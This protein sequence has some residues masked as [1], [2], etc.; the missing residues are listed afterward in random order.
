M[1]IRNYL[2]LQKEFN[3]FRTKILSQNKLNGNKN[4]DADSIFKDMNN[5]DKDN[6]HIFSQKKFIK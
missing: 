4:I 6:L 2:L 1:D 3:D 5:L